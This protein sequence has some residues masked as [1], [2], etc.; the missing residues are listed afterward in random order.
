MCWILVS[1]GRSQWIFSGFFD[2]FCE[3]I[4][5]FGAFNFLAMASESTVRVEEERPS[6]EDGSQ[7]DSNA[8]ETHKSNLD[9]DSDE[10]DE[11][12]DEIRQ[13]WVLSKNSSH[14]SNH[15]SLIKYWR[16][17]KVMVDTLRDYAN[18][19]EENNQKVIEAVYEYIMNALSTYLDAVYSWIDDAKHKEKQAI[20]VPALPRVQKLLGLYNPSLKDKIEKYY[21][22]ALRSPWERSMA[23]SSSSCTSKSAASRFSDESHKFIHS[24]M[25]QHDEEMSKLSEKIVDMTVAT[26]LEQQKRERAEEER[27]RAKEEQKHIEDEKELLW[28]KTQEEREFYLKEKGEFLKQ[29]NRMEKEIAQYKQLAEAAMFPD[30]ATLSLSVNKETPAIATSTPSGMERNGLDSKDGGQGLGMGNCKASCRIGDQKETANANGSQSEERTQEASG[31]DRNSPQK[32]QL[33]FGAPEFISKEPTKPYASLDQSCYHSTWLGAQCDDPKEF[34]HSGRYSTRDYTVSGLPSWKE[35][36]DFSWMPSR[37]PYNEFRSKTGENLTHASR[38][39]TYRFTP[40]FEAPGKESNRRFS[41]KKSDYPMF[42][43][44]L[45]R[46]YHLLWESD[47]YLLLKR[48]ADSVSD[49]VYEHIKGVWVMRNPQEA[50]NR[51]W[52]ILEDLYGDPRGLIET[53]IQDVKWAKGSLASKVASMQAYRT[54]LRNLRS[55]AGSINMLEEL[56]RPKLLFRIVDCFN[57]DLYAEF[58]HENKDFRKWKFDMVLE[59]LDEKLDNLKFKEHNLYDISTII[60]DERSG[61]SKSKDNPGKRGFQARTNNL[62]SAKS[63]PVGKER[64]DD[65]RSRI[66]AKEECAIHCTSGHVTTDC[67][68]LL[69]MDVEKRRDL[70]KTKGL[71][72]LCLGKHLARNCPTGKLCSKCQGS[73]SDLL[74]LERKK[75]STTSPN[76]KENLEDLEKN[77]NSGTKTVRR[78]NIARDSGRTQSLEKEYFASVPLMRLT[79]IKTQGSEKVEVPFYAL[80]DTGADTTIC[81]RELA[82]RLFEWDPRASISIKFLEQTPEDHLCMNRTLCLK[83]G[84]T[85]V[86]ELHDVPFIDAKLPYSDCIPS[87]ELLGMYGL[88][89]HHSHVVQDE[90]RVDMI[91]GAQDL[92]KFRVLETCVWQESDSSELLIG[93]HPLGSILWG[94]R[95]DDLKNEHC[96]SAV[97][98]TRRTN[99][100]EQVMDIVSAEHNIS[101]EECLEL[102]PLLEHDLHRYYKDQL[103]LE[104]NHGEM[105][106]SKDDERILAFYEANVEEIKDSTGQRRLQMP[107]P[108]KEGFPVSVPESFQAAKCRLASQSKRLSKQ[109]ER[110]QKYEETFEAMKREEQ[111]EKV[112]DEEKWSFEEK[113]VH[114]I[115]HFAT[116]QAKFRVVY[117]GALPVNGISLNS[118]LYRGPMFLESLI[119]ILIRFRQ[120]AYAVIGDIKNMFFQIRLHPK[121]RNML[122][123]LPF[124]KDKQNGEEH[125]RFTVMPYGLISI[126]SIAGYC[127][128][129]TAKRNYSRASEDTVRR[130]EQ[131]FY[132]D[133]FITSLPTVEDAKRVAYEVTELLS[134]TGFTLTK[135]ASNSLE[136]LESIGQDRLAPTLKEISFSSQEGLPEQKT[137]GMVWNTANDRMELQN[138]KAARQKDDNLTRR[139][140]LS[141]LNSYFDPLGLWCPFMLKMKL[142]YSLIVSRTC[143]WDDPVPEELQEQ[144]NMLASEMNQLSSLTIPRHYSTLEDG[145]YELH[146]FSDATQEA[147]GACVY[148]RKINDHMIDTALVL[149]KCRIFPSTQVKKFSIARKELLALCMGVDLLQTSRSSLTIS[150]ERIYLW[151]DSTTVIKWCQCHKRELAKFVRNRVDK[152]LTASNNLVPDYISS[153]QNPADVACRGIRVKDEKEYT[154]WTQGPI[155]LRQ[156]TDSWQ[157]G[158]KTLQ[159][160]VNHADLEAEIV[161]QCAKINSVCIDGNSSRILQFLSSCSTRIEA[162]KKLAL[163][164]QCFAALRSL[165]SEDFDISQHKFRENARILLIKLAQEETMGGIIKRMKGGLTFEEALH[166]IPTK[167]RD[168]HL[169]QLKKYVPFLDSTGVLRIGGRVAYSELAHNFRHPL[170][171]PFRHWVTGLYVKQK[172]SDLGHLGPDLVFGALQQDWGLWPV[173]NAKTVRFYTSNCLRCLLVQKSRGQQLMAPLPSARLKPRCSV[174]AYASS[175]LAGPF[176]VS[177][178]RSTVKRWLCIFVCLVTTSIRI[179]VASDLSAT[180]FINVFQRFLCSTGFRTKFIRTDNGTNFTGANNLI[181][182]EVRDALRDLQTTT[183]ESKMDEWEVEWQFGPPEASHHGGV[184]ERQIRTIRKAINGLQPS[185][186]K[187]PTEDEFL[188]ISKMAEYVVN[189]RPLTKSP[190]DDGL[191]PLRPIDLMVGS[192]DPQDGCSYP[193]ITAP[194]DALKRGHRYTQRIASVWWDK[195]LKL[196]VTNLQERQKWRRPMRDFVAG[197][198]ILL[199]EEE[200]PRFLR[201]PYGVITEVKT[202]DD[203]HVRS[204]TARMSDGKLRHRDITKIALIDGGGS[205]D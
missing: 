200:P 34:G 204:V 20:S 7:E 96:I 35:K 78:V 157:V 102:L 105:V 144:W 69:G 29:K 66:T 104:P 67:K 28:N 25:K 198:L 19:N 6:L 61:P 89:Q 70:V 27:K 167:Q 162:E 143:S 57:A 12:L 11:A 92:R 159:P 125:W 65:S 9:S 79:A 178:G 136:V 1:L 74:H 56:S 82:E 155:F 174:F 132:V 120:H 87:D 8:E 101:N 180:S 182:K 36:P 45:L 76:E 114:Y 190:S 138:A 40:M 75:E 191:P 171:L 23:S 151:V 37:G 94:V 196:Y 161:T 44:Q 176:S 49:N 55:I 103:V 163:V 14:F 172:H 139:K 122:R 184:Y 152:I 165:T 185:N 133:D 173:G 141:Q 18:N 116:S 192:L 202:G 39:S 109:P 113:A 183:I 58:A 203:G 84:S 188:T 62:Q 72:Y 149:G 119:G 115:T 110:A 118:M 80:V 50:L 170:I 95:S 148:L 81:N 195:W 5:L 4:L 3:R 175:D 99:Y 179:E 30:A 13:P 46:D 126:P 31:V 64:S 54:K 71:C 205:D 194:A 145:V 24:M 127:V 134:T 16:E 73:H 140:A 21:E 181:R 146:V 129:Y 199:C 60:G 41:G 201:Y 153:N 85:G 53:A 32:T 97:T 59:F 17:L 42:R 52:E 193:T 111:A 197:D 47:P 100:L 186:V 112:E 137:L 164:M 93:T 90:R 169:L 189:C 156:D 142:C 91:F 154:L 88:Q 86:V 123:F 68:Q 38:F 48:V 187:N 121:D 10:I 106:M 107:L 150:V 135:F 26:Q 2:F 43:Q 22:R 160:P 108:W 63:R 33:R 98:T 77:S 168:P 158:M 15:R 128:K 177:I 130:V 131:D 147:M 51:I 124:A 117:N 83:S 166:H